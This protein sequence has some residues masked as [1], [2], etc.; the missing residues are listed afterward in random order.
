LHGPT[1]QSISQGILVRE[2][3]LRLRG[4]GRLTVGTPASLGVR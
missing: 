3:S 2:A 1:N 4:T